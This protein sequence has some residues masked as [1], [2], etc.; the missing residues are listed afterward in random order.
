MFKSCTQAAEIFCSAFDDTSIMDGIT[1]V[2]VIKHK[3]G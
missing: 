1:D 2:I 3:S